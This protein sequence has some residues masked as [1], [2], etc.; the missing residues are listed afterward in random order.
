MYKCKK[1]KKK[2]S[3]TCC[4][5]HID[6]PNENYMRKSMTI[7]YLYNKY[8]ATVRRQLADD[9]RIYSMFRAS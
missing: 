6:F 4:Q 5:I 7:S 8:E 9:E 3:L 2:K 1:K